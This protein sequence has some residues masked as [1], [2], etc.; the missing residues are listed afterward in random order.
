MSS[1]ET[2]TEVQTNTPSVA[3]SKNAI[4]Q[5][6]ESSILEKYSSH[7][8]LPL[9][10]AASVGLHVL[11]LLGIALLGFYLLPGAFTPKPP[12]GYSMV[13]VSGDGGTGGSGQEGGD[14]DSLERQFKSLEYT[15]GEIDSTKKMTP[16]EL[17]VE[18][19]Q[20]K[21]P[22]LP[23]TGKDKR[24]TPGQYGPGSDGGP[25]GNG[26][27]WPNGK[28]LERTS[29]MDRWLIIMPSDD[30]AMFMD[31]LREIEA[32]LVLPLGG[33]QFMMYEDL[34]SQK[35][36]R[37]TTSTELFHL[38]R[39]WYTSRDLDL[40]RGLAADRGMPQIPDY[41]AIFIPQSLERE[42]L[43][44][45]LAFRGRTEKQLMEEHWR[46]SFEV[47]RR[48]TTWI[49]QVREQSRSKP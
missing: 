33:G 20:P 36:G 31:K 6:D 41:I 27:G 34:S 46:T 10:L 7:H 9:S 4:H 12:D 13:E 38:N 11:A 29:R 22:P 43:N 39:I 8:E 40:R 17:P 48:G 2:P 24:A 5:P 26:R 44:K 32:I 21:V 35:A 18:S 30:T 19:N 45:E 49:V 42:L 1:I 47:A 23:Y 3:W 16:L 37:K 28:N 15:P 14:L 25:G